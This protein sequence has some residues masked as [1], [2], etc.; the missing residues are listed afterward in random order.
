[1]TVSIAN[2]RSSWSN[3]AINYTGL[4]LNVNAS[5]YSA[6]SKVI[7]LKV[8][9]NSILSLDA[10]NNFAIGTDEAQPFGDWTKPGLHLNYDYYP[11]ID[12]SLVSD[13]WADLNYVSSSNTSFVTGW[14]GYHRSRG[15]TT[16]KLLVNNGDTLGELYFAGHDGN[17]WIGG[18]GI[19]V[20]V[21]GETGENNVPGRIVFT[22]QSPNSTSLSE[23]MRITSTGA[24]G[25]GTSNP[26]NLL[27]VIGNVASG[28]VKTGVE[29]LATVGRSEIY[30][31][32][33]NLPSG[34][35]Y[36]GVS[37]NGFDRTVYFFSNANTSILSGPSYTER[38][39]ITDNGNVGI[40][41]SLPS[42]KIEMS[43][44]SSR[45]YGD[46]TLTY[47]ES[48]LDIYGNADEYPRVGVFS[49]GGTNYYEAPEF[50][51]Y[52]AR[53]TKASPTEPASGDNA[54]VV[55]G[56]TYNSSVGNF[57]TVAQ[58]DFVQSA[59]PGVSGTAGSILF[60][61]N[62]GTTQYEGTER[63]RITNSGEVYVA[64]TTDRGAYNLQVNGTGV[65]GAGAYVNGSDARIKD[66]IKAIETCT[67]IIKELKPVTFSYKNTFSKD[68]SIQ[69]GFIA[70]D[71][72]EIL[73]DQ[74]YL[75]G[76]VK[77]EDNIM[78]VSYQGL[79]P[80]LTKTLQEALMRIEVLEQEVNKIKS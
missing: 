78:S 13:L 28:D 53:G 46:P 50:G 80:I 70:Q 37:L 39:R 41:T 22:T 48:A 56:R 68:T 16:N 75:D 42:A 69:T 27:H 4:G 2:L 57:V 14:T 33:Q 60:R 59:T 64:G 36:G 10:S 26:G 73:K 77:S 62:D 25:I 61:T 1:M 35:I 23:R 51:L 38:M 43:S 21:D 54:G 74:V 66:N 49:Y 15:T 29:N 58:I 5:A 45:N 6:N 44:L 67:N 20:Q 19:V 52:K 32:M 31:G 65:W 11:E 79:I 18:A 12:F 17:G 24:V 40:G 47:Y 63:M 72:K 71:L 7:N 30:V 3:V 8:N 34:E 76:I 9:N 55:F